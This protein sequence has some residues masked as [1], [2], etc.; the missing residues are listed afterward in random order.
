LNATE[1]KH[2]LLELKEEALRHKP[3]PSYGKIGT[4]KA[5]VD[6]GEGWHNYREIQRELT[7]FM[8]TGNVY[9]F[10]LAAMHPD[11][12]ERQ[13]QED[14]RLSVK[15]PPMVTKLIGQYALEVQRSVKRAKSQRR[16]TKSR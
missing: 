16:G 3:V 10:Q 13:G 6:L 9:V 11:L 15:V 4:L 1:I 2:F 12:I 7:K 8:S 5:M 14:F